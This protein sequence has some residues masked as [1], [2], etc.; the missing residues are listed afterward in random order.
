MPGMLCLYSKLHLALCKKANNHIS[1]NV[2]HIT[3]RLDMDAFVF[4]SFLCVSQAPKPSP[5]VK[6]MLDAGMFY[7]N[8]VLKDFREK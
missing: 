3:V 2:I 5:F 6:E 8:R 4:T 7:T 1:Q